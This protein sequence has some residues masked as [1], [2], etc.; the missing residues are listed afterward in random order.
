M[1]FVSRDF[2]VLFS[3]F[4]INENASFTDYASG[5]RLPDC[6]KLIINRKSDSDVTI[7]QHA[8]IVNFFGV[9]LFL[10]SSLATGPSFMSVSS[11]V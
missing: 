6:S 5:I 2:L 7:F 1:L 3:V 9:V 11:L 10:L 8:I 4:S